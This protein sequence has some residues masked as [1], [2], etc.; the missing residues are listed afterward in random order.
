[1]TATDMGKVVSSL[2]ISLDSVVEAPTSG[3]SPTSTTRWAPPWKWLHVIE[4][5][6]LE[7]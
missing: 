6:R 5:F 2:F 7:R 1:M 4:C 3:T